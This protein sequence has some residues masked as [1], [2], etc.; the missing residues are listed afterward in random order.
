[1][2][3][4]DKLRIGDSD[5]ELVS[6]L[7]KSAVD[8]GRLSLAEYDDRLQQVYDAKTVGD[9]DPITGDLMGSS[10]GVLAVGADGALSAAPASRP[11]RPRGTPPWIRWMWFGWLIPVLVTTVVWVLSI[12]SGDWVGFWPAWVAGPLGAVMLGVTVMERFMIRPTLHQRDAERA[13]AR[14]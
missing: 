5:R 8:E 3:D 2:N 13:A 14:E 12:L 6:R 4:K 11:V 10:R 9:L 1:M 7:L